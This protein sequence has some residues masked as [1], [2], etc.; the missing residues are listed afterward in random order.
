MV[1]LDPF[2]TVFTKAGVEA[3]DQRCKVWK[4]PINIYAKSF[5]PLECWSWL[6]NARHQNIVI[7]P[8]LSEVFHNTQ[9]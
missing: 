2:Q 5:N 9:P 4:L 3:A 1:I 8:I 7:V 6:Q